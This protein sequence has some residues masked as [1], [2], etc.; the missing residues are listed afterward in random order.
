ME[1]GAIGLILIVWFVWGAF[2]K[3][4]LAARRHRG[5]RGD[6][7]AACAAAGAAFAASL[8]VFDTLAFIQC[9]LLF[10]IVAALGL[11]ARQLAD[12]HEPRI[13]A[14]P[15]LATRGP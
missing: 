4:G 14:A 6:R 7:L 5:I 13:A 11:R 15:R 3:P 8:F 9:S 1:L 2:L 10:F 12:E